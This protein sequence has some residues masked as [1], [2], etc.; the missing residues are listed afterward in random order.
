V[1][2][3][4]ALILGGV[5]S[6]AQHPIALNLVAQ[7]YSAQGSRA[8]L[9]TYNFAGDLGKIALPS[10]TAALLLLMPWRSAALVLGA[11]VIVADLCAAIFLAAR[12]L[13]PRRG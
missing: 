6:S 2:L 13:S 9:A 12:L 1:I 8:P 5:G 7:A 11:T 3:A 4:E 10:G